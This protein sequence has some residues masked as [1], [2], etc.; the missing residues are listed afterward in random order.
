MAEMAV[1]SAAGSL[2]LVLAIRM[3]FARV[4]SRRL[5]GI[6]A[7]M[8]RLAEGDSTVEAPPQDRADEIGAMARAVAVF[9]QHAIENQMAAVREEGH[10]QAISKKNATLQHMAE[11]IEV[12]T[13]AALEQISHR[14]STMA[15][16]AASMTASALRTGAAADSASHAGKTRR[17]LAN[18]QTV[19]SAAEQLAAS[20]R[21]ISGQVGQ[22]TAVVGRAVTAGGAG[23]CGTIE[24]LEFN[25]GGAHRRGEAEHHPGYRRQAHQ[26]PGAGT[27]H[28]I[29]EAARAVVIAAGK[30]FARGGCSEGEAARQPDGPVHR[31]D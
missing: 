1:A 22:S 11:T 25:Q 16:T 19:A 15:E 17:G 4:I 21:E 12:E 9:K 20:I 10:R 8:R 31:G 26:S 5:N 24:A 30:G 28:W 13:G 18:A 6:T 7:V 14:T 27:G 23:N 2:M 29:A 3:I